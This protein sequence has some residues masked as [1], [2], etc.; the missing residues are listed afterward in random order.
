[1]SVP[2][3]RCEASLGVALLER[4]AARFTPSEAIVD[5]IVRRTI[6]TASTDP[7]LLTGHDVKI[8]LLTL[9]RQ[10]ALEELGERLASRELS[11]R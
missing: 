7:G 11:V 5:R 4:W 9:L 10:V 1:M 6:Q 3:S 8:D 2:A